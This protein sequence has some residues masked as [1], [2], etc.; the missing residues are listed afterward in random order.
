MCTQDCE[1]RTRATD[2]E[3]IIIDKHTLQVSSIA[4]WIIRVF[5]GIYCIY[6]ITNSNIIDKTR[7]YRIE[8][9]LTSYKYFKL[10]SNKFDFIHIT[11]LHFNLYIFSS[12][13][14][15]NNIGTFVV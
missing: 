1:Q 13:V 15:L 3:N 12:E 10:I 2:N 14:N 11:K 6:N 9:T 8:Q 4:R 5:I 7:K